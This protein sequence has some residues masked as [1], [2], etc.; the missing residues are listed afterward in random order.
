MA[1]SQGVYIQ[2]I[3]IRSDAPLLGPCKDFNGVVWNSYGLGEQC[4]AYMP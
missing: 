3:A 1:F 2:V 4:M